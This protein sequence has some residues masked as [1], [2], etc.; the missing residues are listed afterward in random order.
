MLL[1]HGHRALLPRPPAGAARVREPRPRRRGH[2]RRGAC[3]PCIR[4]P[5]GCRSRS[6][7]R[8]VDAH[9]DALLPPVDG[10]PPARD[11]RSAAGVPRHRR[12]AAHGAP[13][14]SRSP[15]RIAGRD[16]A[17]VRGAVLRA[18][19]A[20]SGRRRWRARRGAA[21]VREQARPHDPTARVAAVSRSRMRRCA[22]MREIVADMCSDRRMH[23]LLQGDVGSGKTIVALF[24]ALLAMENGY[25][26][27]IMA[28]T[29]LLAEQHHRARSPRCSRPLGVAPVLL[30]G[31]LSAPERDARA[32]TR[33]RRRGGPVLV[34]GTHALVQEAT[35][36]RAARPRRHRRAAPVRRGAARG[37][38]RPRARR[39]TCC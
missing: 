11:P 23:R 24:A 30:T 38:R 2:R 32:A 33:L 18:P 27:A 21:S 15:R 28:P 36:V 19:A 14:R 12:R 4:P 6:S 16:A 31:S 29:E 39:P 13:A 5:K 35:R 1:A 37:A 34:V 25:Q 7:A 20:R 3:S 22:R 17:R 10:V 26:A 9:L 8:I